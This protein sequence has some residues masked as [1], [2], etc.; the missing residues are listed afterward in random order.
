MLFG[1]FKY[2]DR[3][4]LDWRHLRFFT[5]KSARELVEQQGYRITAQHFTVMPFERVMSLAPGSLLLRFANQT[6]RLLARMSP[7]L[8]AYEI[9]LVAERG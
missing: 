9:I 8:F 3:G 7:G 2:A 6:L 1:T 4:I 5:R